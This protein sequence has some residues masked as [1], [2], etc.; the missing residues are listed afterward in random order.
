MNDFTV[1]KN[2]LPF[3][4]KDFLKLMA[5]YESAMLEVKTKLEVLKTE[6]SLENDRNPFKQISYRLKEPMS[7]IGKLQRYGVELSVESIEKNLHD[8]AGVRVICPFVDD[9][10]MLSNKLCSQ[11]DIHVLTRKD[12]IENPKPNGYRSLHLIIEVPIFLSNEKK[13]M[14]VEVQFRTIAM[15]FWASLEHK[16]KY[17]KNIPSADAVSAR[18]KACADEIAAVDMRMQDVRKQIEW[19]SEEL[20]EEEK[21]VREEHITSQL[22]MQML[23]N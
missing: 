9:I 16:M 15:D 2:I 22:L 12:Y 19:L 1:Q 8:V 20:P 17:K 5:Q 7:I 18:L 4:N 10:Y 13:M 14:Q 23:R 6:M 3:V 11:D 21:A